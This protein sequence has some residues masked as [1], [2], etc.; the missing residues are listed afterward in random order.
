MDHAVVIEQESE[1]DQD[2][3]ADD[4]RQHMADA[5]HQMLVCLPSKAVTCGICRAFRLGLTTA[6][7]NGRM[8]G[9][10][11]IEE[12]IRFVDTVCNLAD[13]DFLSLKARHGDVF[14]RR[15]DD[16]VSSCD[17]G[18]GQYVLRAARTIRLDLD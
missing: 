12:F 15:N 3:A 10:R 11:L 2:A 4:K 6:L 16:A 5:V 9:K 14:I 8:S 1:G 13:D 18:I 17:L 7:V